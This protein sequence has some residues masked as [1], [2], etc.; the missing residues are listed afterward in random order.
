MSAANNFKIALR[1]I[2]LGSSFSDEQPSLKQVE[3][4]EPSATF[5]FYD[6]DTT[7]VSR[8]SRIEGN[9]Y[10]EGHLNVSGFVDGNIAAK[11]NVSAAGIINGDLNCNALVF[12]FGE[13]N[14]EVSAVSN[15]T[16]GENA[17]VNGNLYAK[18]LNAAGKVMGR[19]VVTEHA[20]FQS[21]AVISGDIK[22]KTISADQG[23]VLDGRANIGG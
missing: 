14:G 16:I 5:S 22:S 19:L 23:A 18:N 21:T 17:I 8:K 1:E 20:H 7:V 3:V 2:F 6:S 10:S 15:V 4:T 11:G 9:V 13:I 12:E